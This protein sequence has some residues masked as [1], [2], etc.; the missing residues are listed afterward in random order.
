MSMDVA[1]LQRI[2]L[3]WETARSQAARAVNTAHVCANRLIGQQIVEAEQGG[4]E[5]A[6]YGSRC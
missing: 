2:R 3:I 6:E 4:T 1:L 5:R